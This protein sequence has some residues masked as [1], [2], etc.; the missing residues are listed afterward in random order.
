MDDTVGS[1]Q[2]GGEWTTWWGV[3]DTVVSGRHGG[4]WTTRW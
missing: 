3:D 4:E 2:H 1:G